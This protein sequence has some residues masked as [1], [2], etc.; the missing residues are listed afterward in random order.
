MAAD[1]RQLD[2]EVAVREVGV[3]VAEAR[4]VDLDED[5]GV[6]R[7][8][9]LEV[10]DLPVLADGLDDGSAGLHALSFVFWVVSAAAVASAA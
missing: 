10:D 4:G 9:E 6:V 5:L 1:E 8:A 7:L 3:R 2:L